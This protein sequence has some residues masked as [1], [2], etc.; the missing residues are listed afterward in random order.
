MGD[1]SHLGLQK[2]MGESVSMSQTTLPLLNLHLIWWERREGRANS[3]VRYTGRL[4]KRDSKVVESIYRKKQSQKLSLS[5]QEPNELTI[6]RQTAHLTRKV[7]DSNL[8]PVRRQ[9]IPPW[10]KREKLRNILRN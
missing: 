9:R 2:R 3:R 1:Q 8:A 6:S 7:F 5:A 10:R 4:S